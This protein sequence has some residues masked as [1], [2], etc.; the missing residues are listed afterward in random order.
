MVLLTACP[1][2]IPT[3]WLSITQ[4]VVNQRQRLVGFYYKHTSAETSEAG[5]TYSTRA[6]SAPERHF[7]QSYFCYPPCRP[8]WIPYTTL[9][10]GS[11]IISP[12]GGDTIKYHILLSFNVKRCRYNSHH[13][14]RMRQPAKS[15]VSKWF[16]FEI[17]STTRNIPQQKHPRQV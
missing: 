13:R 6:F 17:K 15:S 12:L 14:N 3:Q 8:T 9:K 1:T 5:L 7:R 2:I 10:L 16:N 4:T 11:F